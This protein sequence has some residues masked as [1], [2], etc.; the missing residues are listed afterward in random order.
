MQPMTDGH[1]WLVFNG[2]IYNFRQLRAEI[3]RLRPGYD[4]KTT[5]DSE[6]ILASLSLLG[7]EMRRAFQRHVRPGH[8]GP[9]GRQLSLPGIAWD[10]SHFILL[11]PRTAGPSRLPASFRP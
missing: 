1:R 10:K 9:A 8:L 6:V 4:W 5:G 7:N 3:D 2:E 11:W